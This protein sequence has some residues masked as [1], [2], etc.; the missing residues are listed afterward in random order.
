[1]MPSDDI[2]YYERSIYNLLDLLGD[3]GGF[4]DCLDDLA[5]L[6]LFIFSTALGDGPHIHMIETVFKTKGKH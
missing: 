3:I 4:S 5:M 1:M 2:I 6:I